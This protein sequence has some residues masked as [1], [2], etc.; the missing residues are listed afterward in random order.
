MVSEVE[1]ALLR[2]KIPVD[3]VHCSPTF[4]NGKINFATNLKLLDSPAAYFF[5]R[6]GRLI[7]SDMANDQCL[8]ILSPNS[9]VCPFKLTKRLSV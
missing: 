9:N 4:V 8:D 6:L 7:I 3:G 5:R 2:N 1:K